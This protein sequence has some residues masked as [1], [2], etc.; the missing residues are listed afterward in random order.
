MADCGQ[1]DQHHGI[2]I[3][4]CVGSLQNPVVTLPPSRIVRTLIDDAAGLAYEVMF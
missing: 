4:E 2:G 3:S 1:M